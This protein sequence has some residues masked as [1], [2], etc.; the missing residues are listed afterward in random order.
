MGIPKFGPR[1]DADSHRNHMKAFKTSKMY[2]FV[3]ECRKRARCVNVLHLS[4]EESD[5]GM[6]PVID[7]MNMWGYALKENEVNTGSIDM[8]DRDGMLQACYDADILI[9]GSSKNKAKSGDAGYM[10][11]LVCDGWFGIMPHWDVLWYGLN[12]YTPEGGPEM[13]GVGPVCSGCD[14]TVDAVSMLHAH[15]RRRDDEAAMRGCMDLLWGEVM[16]GM[17]RLS[18]EVSESGKYIVEAFREKLTSDG[19]NDK[20]LDVKML[21]MSLKMLENG[22]RSGLSTAFMVPEDVAED[23]QHLGGGAEELRKSHRRPLD[24]PNDQ[25]PTDSHAIEKWAYCMAYTAMQWVKEYHIV[26]VWTDWHEHMVGRPPG[27]NLFESVKQWPELEEKLKQRPSGFRLQ[28]MVTA[29]LHAGGVDVLGAECEKNNGPKC[30]CTC[31]TCASDKTDGQTKPASHATGPT[32]CRQAGLLGSERDSCLCGCDNCS[33]HGWH[34]VDVK[35]NVCGLDVPIQIGS[36][37]GSMNHDKD[38]F[39]TTSSTPYGMT[40]GFL[41]TRTARERDTERIRK[42]LRQTPPDGIALIIDF[43]QYGMDVEPNV[44]W[45]YGGVRDKCM[46][47][48]D[49]KNKKSRIYHSAPKQLVDAAKQVCSA[50]GSDEQTIHHIQARPGPGKCPP[51]CP[52]TIEGLVNA[53]KRDPVIWVADVTGALRYPE[54][55]SAYCNSVKGLDGLRGLVSAIGHAVDTY[56]ESKGCEDNRSWLRAIH[57]SLNALND[58]LNDSLERMHVSELAAAVCVLRD[59]VWKLDVEKSEYVY[60]SRSILAIHEKPHLDALHSMVR[61]VGKL[62]NDAPPETL[63]TLTDIAKLGKWEDGTGYRII[64]GAML[65]TLASSQPKWYA[66]NEPLLFGAPDGLDVDLMGAYMLHNIGW[67]P[68]MEKYPQL[69]RKAVLDAGAERGDNRMYV[70]MTYVLNGIKGYDMKDSILFLSEAGILG[71]A[72]SVCAWLVNNEAERTGNDMKLCKAAIRFWETALECV[73][74]Q[75]GEFGSMWLAKPAMKDRWNELMLKT[76]E[77]SEGGIAQPVHVAARVFDDGYHE[78]GMKVLE[79]ILRAKP[80]TVGDLAVRHTLNQMPEDEYK[81]LSRKLGW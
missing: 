38:V 32:D 30:E 71:V 54:Y 64:L 2:R 40:G 42:K 62:G 18:R 45:W 33:G 27:K 70:F 28:A 12:D 81:T 36:F 57:D 51:F 15:I 67:R 9:V 53:M 11:G 6:D 17:A 16:V 77:L 22:R 65:N 61:I 26:R 4:T 68:I 35:V 10:L 14:F 72:V 56:M 49:V 46:V 63:K 80:E 29:M 3:D 39:Q 21:V 69:A 8:S 59:V 25:Y 73:P 43:T 5:K 44:G 37:E 7:R 55:V 78:S 47:L 34:D 1:L 31:Q 23:M 75:A 19:L 50:L 24:P 48:L 60:T 79:L 58:L 76:C 74:E 20:H 13:F 41:D 52:D 66:E